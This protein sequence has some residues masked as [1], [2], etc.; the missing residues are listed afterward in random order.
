MAK[1]SR[2]R[3][4]TLQFW[5]RKRAEKPLHRVNWENFDNHKSDTEGVLGFI[6][7]KVGMASALVKDETANSMTKGKRM[8]VPVTILE[9]PNMKIFSIRFYKNTLPIKDVV[10][11]HDKELKKVLRVPKA[12]KPLDSMIPKEYDDIHLIAYSLPSQTTVK[13]VPD[14]IE[15]AIHAKDKLAFAKSLIGKEI[16]LKD[17]LNKHDLLDVRGLTR[18][19]GLV[20]PVK[21]FGITLKAHKSEKG[22]RRP[23]SL[24]PWHPARV[25]F[26]TPHAGQLGM[27]SRIHYNFKVITS[28]SI[29]QKNINPGTGFKHYGNIKGNYIVILGSVQG[30]VKRQV[31]LTPSF[32]PTKL[33]AKKKFEFM[34]LV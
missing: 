2:P 4:G 5:P 34:E 12:L 10:V 32:R 8:V 23:G 25:T 17:F 29:A 31:L 16:A 27:F 11:S 18:G 30:P 26:H 1:L 14:V 19:K 24:S 7:Y 3:S 9:A 33:Q 13:K 22:V 21:R 15:L 28:N 6:T 20:G